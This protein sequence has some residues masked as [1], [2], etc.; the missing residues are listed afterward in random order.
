M[1]CSTVSGNMQAMTEK[2]K[3]PRKKESAEAVKKRVSAYRERAAD[4]NLV[5]LDLYVHKDDK[6]MIEIYARS[7]AD[8]RASN[9]CSKHGILNCQNCTATTA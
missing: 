8:Q 7:L 3:K 6:P 1:Q 9:V 5:R 4:M 2:I